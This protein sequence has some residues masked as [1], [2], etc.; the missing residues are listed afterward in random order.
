MEKE[1]LHKQVN[2]HFKSCQDAQFAQYIIVRITTSEL[3][4]YLSPNIEAV[5]HKVSITGLTDVAVQTSQL[6]PQSMLLLYR[7]VTS[8]LDVSLHIMMETVI[9]LQKVV[10]R[11]GQDILTLSWPQREGNVLC[12]V[13][14]P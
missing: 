10:E 3:K 4:I 14:A 8:T 13:P 2:C 6:C 9:F 11:K 5:G 1:R 12:I 7:T